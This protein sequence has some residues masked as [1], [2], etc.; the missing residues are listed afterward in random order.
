[1]RCLLRL[2]RKKVRE[3]ERQTGCRAKIE[4][5]GKG[6]RERGRKILMKNSKTIFREKEREKNER[7]NERQ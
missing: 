2:R 7:K 6:E 5:E 1:M 3:G 4:R